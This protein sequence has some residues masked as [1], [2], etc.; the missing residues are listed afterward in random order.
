[1]QAGDD[2]M[3]DDGTGW[4]NPL[5]Y[6]DIEYWRGQHRRSDGDRSE[7]NFERTMD[8]PARPRTPSSICTDTDVE[9]DSEA[10]DDAPAG[11][12]DVLA[13]TCRLLLAGIIHGG[14]R[15][16]DRC[17]AGTASGK[18]P[19]PLP[20]CEYVIN[21]LSLDIAACRAVE[22]VLGEHSTSVDPW[23]SERV[24][25]PEYKYAGWTNRA[26]LSMSPGHIQRRKIAIDVIAW[27]H[28][29][30]AHLA[31]YDVDVRVEVD[32]EVGVVRAYDKICT[33]PL[34][35]IQASG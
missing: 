2:D 16:S 13:Q 34:T 19:C 29:Q 14:G 7:S 23:T 30:S 3:L 27:Q 20:R 6:T 22:S 1:M 15:P 11:A 8:F 10:E 24:L 17:E 31:S 32:E 18:W 25:A 35:W 12:G 4:D 21:L 26:G 5:A 28:L 9:C 33:L